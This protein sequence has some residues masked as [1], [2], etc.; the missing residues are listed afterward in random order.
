[1]TDRNHQIHEFAQLLRQWTGGSHD[2]FL[3]ELSEKTRNWPADFRN[4]TD[5]VGKVAARAGHA[6]DIQSVGLREMIRQR[7]LTA[8]ALAMASGVLLASGPRR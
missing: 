5:A 8:I 6:N 2:D 7:P 1:M 4:L 3:A